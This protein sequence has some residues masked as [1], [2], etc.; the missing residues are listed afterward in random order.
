MDEDKKQKFLDDANAI[1]DICEKNISCETCQFYG[2]SCKGEGLEEYPPFAWPKTVYVDEKIDDTK[3]Q[4]I[5]EA[6]DTL[7]KFCDSRLCNHACPLY[8]NCT[9]NIYEWFKLE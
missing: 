8:V 7:Q 6:I 4:K 1:I 5:N 9:R 3:K 2:R